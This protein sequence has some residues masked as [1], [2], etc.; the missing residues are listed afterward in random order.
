MT[1]TTMERGGRKYFNGTVQTHGGETRGVLRIEAHCHDVVYVA[2][3]LLPI[4]SLSRKYAHQGKIVVPIPHLDQHIISTRQDIGER[5]VHIQSTDKIIVR[6][7]LLHLPVN[8]RSST[9]FLARIVVVHTYLHIVTPKYDPLLSGNESTATDGL[10]SRF[11]VV[12]NFLLL[13][14]KNDR[15]SREKAEKHPGLGRVVIDALHAITLL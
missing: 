14:V 10:I 11:E 15:L 7:P 6:H 3:K 8:R 2:F 12:S 4:Q 1:R 9:C 5:F 13:D